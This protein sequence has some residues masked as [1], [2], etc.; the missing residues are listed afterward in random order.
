MGYQIRHFDRI[1]V[2]AAAEGPPGTL[3]SQ[4]K[5]GAQLSRWPI[6]HGSEPYTNRNGL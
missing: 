4:L 1:I 2:T 5:P 3:L 6:Q